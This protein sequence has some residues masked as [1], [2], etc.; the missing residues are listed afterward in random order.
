MKNLQLHI[1]FFRAISVLLVFFYH[2]ELEYFKFGY[3]GVDIFFVISGY[4]ITS[5]LFIEFIKTNRVNFYSFF[6]RR[7]K[8]IF[9]VLFFIL[10]FVLIFIVLF[11]PLDLFVSN[12]KVYFFTIFGL[13]NFY[14]LF[15]N[16]DYFDNVF[17]DVFGHTWSLGIE[18]QFY[19]IFPF[20]LYFLCT[21]FSNKKHQILIIMIIIF[22]GIF[23]TY[24]FSSNLQLIFYSPIFRFWEFLLG[25]II[26]LINQKYQIKNSIISI[27][28]FTFL[29][30]LILLN[31]YLNNFTAILLSTVLASSFILFYD[32]NNKLSFLFENKF[33]VYLGNISYSFYLWHLPIIY[34][35]NLYFG[36]SFIK[37]PIIFFLTII[38]ST[39]SYKFI[40][41]KFRYKNYNIRKNK[42][43]LPSLFTAF[44]FL[45]FFYYIATQKSYENIIKNNIK[46]FAHSINFLE[47]KLNYSERAIFYKIKIS[48]NEIYR[49][50]TEDSKEY[51]VN[52]NNL[53]KQ[54]LKEGLSKNRIFFVEGNSHTANYIPLFNKI[55]QNSKDSIY[56]EHTSEVLSDQTLK[57]IDKLKKVYK[58][59]VFV[60]N[61][62]NYNLFVLDK[63]NEKLKKNIKVLLLSTIPNLNSDSEPLKCFIKN[64]NC[65]YSTIDDY[66]DRN[67]NN[68]FLKI[69]EFI[70]KTQNH[71]ALFYNSYYKICPNDICYSYNNVKDVLSHRDISHLTIEGSVLLENDFLEFYTKHY[72]NN[73]KN[74]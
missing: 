43:I 39:V 20:F 30:S 23:F 22:F 55:F 6:I 3:L 53:R 57:K 50:C 15:S 71:R 18:E 74:D 40:E 14:Y 31:L 44:S 59:V 37:M 25:S 47:R 52:I 1:Q 67:L 21:L 13:S 19:L 29:I 10:S 42:I 73:I 26:F 38:L 16:R 41:N 28:S 72:T 58:E 70:D 35:Y 56:Y 32:E 34:F 66:N 8:R 60:T 51:N 62:E 4:V 45:I 12:I 64:T 63:I 54:C 11:Q 2:L 36:H 7:I 65:T 46:D 49:F 33:F 48:G 17:E 9:P 69:N 5:R 61:I 27:L 68:Y 24:K